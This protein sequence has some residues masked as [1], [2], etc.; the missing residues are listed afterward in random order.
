MQNIPTDNFFVLTGGDR[1]G[2]STLLAS[3]ASSHPEWEIA[4]LN[5]QDWLPVPDLPHLDWALDRHPRTVIHHLTPIARATTLLNYIAC[6][7]EYWLQPRL[8]DGKVVIV[9]SY[10]YRFYIK[11][12]LKQLVPDFFYQ[13]LDLLPNANTAVI[14]T[15]APEIAYQR[16]DEFCVH[17]RYEGDSIKSFLDFQS[18][19]S[20]EL[21]YLCNERCVSTQFI[22]ANQPPDKLLQAFIDIV[23][24]QISK[25]QALQTSGKNNQ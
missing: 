1:V 11:E 19:V 15:L 7:Y 18:D 13:A 3:L 17:E 10:Y 16:R 5:P 25:N 12:K 21:S 22:D 20:T 23:Q 24:Q 9:D 14:A 4:G 6:F 2:K 8:L